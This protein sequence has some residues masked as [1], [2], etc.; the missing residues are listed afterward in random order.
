MRWLPILMIVSVT[1][2]LCY[3]A[4]LSTPQTIDEPNSASKQRV[5]LFNP[6]MES[7]PAFDRHSDQK[8]MSSETAFLHSS[9]LDAPKYWDLRELGKEE[10]EIKNARALLDHLIEGELLS[11]HLPIR[12]API[13]TSLQSVPNSGDMNGIS[14]L[15]GN[16]MSTSSLE[17]LI[18]V[19]SESETMMTFQLKDRSWI[20]NIDNKTAEGVLKPDFNDLDN[21]SIH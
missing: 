5:S 12:T 6:L 3:R 11:L 19:K 9:K 14:I 20:A 2:Y 17:H 21:H 4:S 8:T 1:A 16:I 13:Q 15:K 18:I 10:F 7:P